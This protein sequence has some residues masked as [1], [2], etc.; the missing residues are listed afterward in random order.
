MARFADRIIANSRAGRDWVVSQGFPADRLN[1]IPNGIDTLRFRPCAEERARVRAEWNIAPEE[2]LIG[3][4]ARID[5][6]KDHVNFLQA[7]SQA[8]A[9]NPRLRFVC[10]GETPNASYAER[11]RAESRALGLENRLIWSPPRN[12]MPAVYN[13]LDLLTLTSYG[14]GFPNVIGEAMASEIPCVVTDAGDSAWVVG[15]TG[16]V[17][18]CRDPAKLALG[19]ETLLARSDA[20]RKAMGQAAR[21]RIASLFSVESL[22]VETERTLRAELAPSR[23]LPHLAL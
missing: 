8:A 20:E 5:P 3:L 14:E 15:E 2:L 7:A 23:R 13:A 17:V 12:D 18:P 11:L 19:F 9:H 10:V 6:I 22:T 4:A 16:L 1:V 21:Q